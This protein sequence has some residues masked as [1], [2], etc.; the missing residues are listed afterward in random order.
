MFVSQILRNTSES[1][2]V[3]I[4]LLTQPPPP[5]IMPRTSTTY[6]PE[7]DQAGTINFAFLWFQDD[8][9]LDHICPEYGQ[10]GTINHYGPEYDQPEI[11][12]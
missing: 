1:F 11:I 9:R 3:H 8:H 5:L 2:V 4:W 6:G 12:L 10:P 7:Y